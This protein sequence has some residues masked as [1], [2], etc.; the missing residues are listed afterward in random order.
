[1]TVAELVQS[2]WF[3]GCVAALLTLIITMIGAI[4]IRYERG[5]LDIASLQAEIKTLKTELH[6]RRESD[7]I[8]F[9][10]IDS[11]SMATARMEGKLDTVIDLMKGKD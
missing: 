10:K 7:K 3:W 9:A 5:I 4:V 6:N 11:N 8:L 2:E 1:M